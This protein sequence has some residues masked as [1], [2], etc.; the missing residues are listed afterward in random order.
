[1]IGIRSIA[2]G[3]TYR[4]NCFIVVRSGRRSYVYKTATDCLSISIGGNEGKVRIK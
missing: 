2:H 3:K 1:M 4:R